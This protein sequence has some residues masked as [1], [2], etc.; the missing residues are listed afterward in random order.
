[1]RFPL[2]LLR[3]LFGPAAPQY[4][5][6][7]HHRILAYLRYI[8]SGAAADPVF[9]NRRLSTDL[10]FNSVSMA[11]LLLAVIRERG[12]ST[13]AVLGF[14]RVSPPQGEGRLAN[15]LERTTLLAEELNEKERMLLLSSGT[16]GDPSEVV[17]LTGEFDSVRF[18]VRYCEAIEVAG[19]MAPKQ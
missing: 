3:K 19:R 16:V 5:P 2:E 18:V 7:A 4:D 13:E 9:E 15:L 8:W 12:L 14:M 1:M 10:G 17:F 6:T 11:E